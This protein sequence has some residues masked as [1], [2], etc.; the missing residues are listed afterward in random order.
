M[1]TEHLVMLGNYWELFKDVIMYS[2]LCFFKVSLC[3]KNT[4]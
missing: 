1:V 2:W 4:H 3:F